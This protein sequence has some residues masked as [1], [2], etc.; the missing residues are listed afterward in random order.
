[1]K[2][3][4]VARVPHFYGYFSKTIRDEKL[5]FSGFIDQL[6]LKKKYWLIPRFDFPRLHVARFE[7]LVTKC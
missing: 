2:I 5:S 7:G 4:R 1:V 6:S 3:S